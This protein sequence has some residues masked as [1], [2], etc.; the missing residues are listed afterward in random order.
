MYACMSVHMYVCMCA[1]ISIKSLLPILLY[2]YFIC[3]WTNMQIWP[4]QP[5]CNIGI[6]TQYVAYVCQNTTNCNIYFMLLP[7]M[8]HQQICLPNATY[9]NFVHVIQPC[10]YKCL[11]WAQCN[12]Q[13][14]L[15]HW[16]TYFPIT[17]ICHW[18]NIPMILHTYTPLYYCCSFHI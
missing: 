11:I 9:T 18:T 16:Y 13:C 7:H 1:C 5:L 3:H 15:D 10:Q 14:D 12:Q 2:T 8:G 6:Q 4:M 17:C